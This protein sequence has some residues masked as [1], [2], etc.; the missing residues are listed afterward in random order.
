MKP[1]WRVL[2][3]PVLAALPA[4]FA[5]GAS[6]SAELKPS[7]TVPDDRLARLHERA[8]T[9]A[10]ELGQLG[11]PIRVS[12]VTLS[13]NENAPSGFVSRGRVD[14][15]EPREVEIGAF[16]T[17]REL[18]GAKDDDSGFGG[19]ALAYYDIGGQ[20]VVFNDSQLSRSGDA[21]QVVAHELVHVYQDQVQGGIETY[22]RVHSRGMDSTL[23]AHAVSEG[24]AQLIAR[25]LMYKR[26][27]ADLNLRD[28]RIKN[29][30]LSRLLAESG[31]GGPY[32]L[33]ED[34]L[35]ARYRVGGFEAV[36]AAY[37]RPPSSTEQLLHPD[38]YERDLPRIVTL[39]D[40]P[41]PT[42]LV[43]RVTEESFGEYALFAALAES[44]TTDD[45]PLL[46]G[47]DEAALASVG[48]DGDRMA[49]YRLHDGRRAALFRSVWDSDEA[50]RGFVTAVR[51]ALALHERERSVRLVQRAAVVD[52]A[53]SE[54]TSLLPA[55]VQALEQHP[56]HFQPNAEDAESTRRARLELAERVALAPSVEQGT[57]LHPLSAVRVCIPE[58]WKPRPLLG[59]PVIAGDASHGVT[60]Y[61]A[62]QQVTDL[63]GG[64]LGRFLDASIAQ[65]SQSSLNAGEVAHE[66]RDVAGVRAGVLTLTLGRRKP[67]T[68]RIWVL[69]RAGHYFLLGLRMSAEAWPGE[70]ALVQ[71][72]ERGIAIT[73]TPAPRASTRNTHSASA[74]PCSSN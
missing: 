35:W 73:D 28:P 38:K 49:V 34:F 7:Q 65:I 48:W 10:R 30:G 57:W 27:G 46:R 42:A 50:A 52:L 15:D 37:H 39:P 54:D 17:L 18:L 29:D 43:R 68:L 69:P 64:D 41:D 63:H 32:V 47:G 1:S 26:Q 5:C 55:L 58:G 60:P 66:L 2:V 13:L 61:I 14:A 11:F 16:D 45:D 71:W 51:R 9:I 6:Q 53:F 44:L 19:V 59:V 56:R 62:V 33:G 70:Q 22:D 67:T 24:E 31:V 74:N 12:E 21:D 8:R 40:W 23:A 72:L 36:L 20:Y 3:V 4:A 25:A